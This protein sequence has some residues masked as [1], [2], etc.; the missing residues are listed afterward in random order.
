MAFRRIFRRKATTRASLH[1]SSGKAEERGFTAR[2][3]RCAGSDYRRR[4]SLD[5]LLEV[6]FQ[7]FEN[8]ASVQVSFA[9]CFPL[10]SSR[11]SGAACARDRGCGYSI[12]LDSDQHFAIL[13]ETTVCYNNCAIASQNLL[14]CL[15]SFR[16]EFELGLKLALSPSFS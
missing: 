1:F 12:A 13:R 4:F 14:V 6:E 3:F 9:F 8:R 7:N 2:K 15:R 5:S 11:D 16:A 10:A